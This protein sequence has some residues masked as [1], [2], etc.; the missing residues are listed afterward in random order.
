MA[1]YVSYEQMQTIADSIGN[2]FTTLNNTINIINETVNETQ[3]VIAEEFDVS[4]SYNVGDILMYDKKLYKCI[5]PHSA[6]E[7]NPLNFEETTVSQ[8]IE[9]AQGGGSVIG[10]YENENLFIHSMRI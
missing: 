3:N 1:N 6:G 8:L 10:T 5:S 7:W 4:K 2:N 9:E